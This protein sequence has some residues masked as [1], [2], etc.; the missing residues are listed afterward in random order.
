MKTLRH[1]ACLHEWEVEES[2]A[3]RV[4]NDINGGLG[5]AS[6]PIVCPGCKVPSR[7]SEFVVVTP[8]G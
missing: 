8:D 3:S 7:Y 1:K 5:P 6:P 4:E 2:F